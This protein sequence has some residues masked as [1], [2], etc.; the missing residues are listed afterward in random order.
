MSER[1]GDRVQELFDRAVALPPARRAAFLAATCADEPALHAEVASLLACDAEFTEGDGDAGVLKSPLVRAPEPANSRADE[2]PPAAW[3]PGPPVRIGRYRVLRRI[4]EGGMGAVYE[5]EQDSPHRLVA[6]KVIRPGLLSP[7][8]LKRF[9]QEVDVLGR[10]RHPGIAQIHE[11][12]MA[13]DG[14]PFFAMEL[15]RGLPLDEYADGQVLDLAARVGLVARVCDAVQHAHDRGVI[16]RDLKPANIL[17]EETGQPKVLDFGVARATGADLLTAAGLTRTGQLLGTPNYMS[18][19]QVTADPA[20]VDRRADV[21]ALGVILFELA[22]HRLPYRLED[23]PLAEAARLIMEHDPPRLGSLDPELGGDVETI[24]AKALEKDPA[25][26]YQSAATLAEDLR[27]WLAHKPILARPPSAL[28]HLGKFARRNKALVGGVAA[29]G[30]ALV[31]GLVGTIL[32]AVGEAKQRGL[33]EQNARAAIAEKREALFQAYRARLSAATAAISAHDVADAADQLEAA[34]E[35]LRDW[36]WRHLHSRLDDSSSVIP[37]PAGEHGFLLH[38]SDRLQV[39]KLTG[40]GL[41]LMNLEGGEDTTVPIDLTRVHAVDA[42]ATRRGLR[43]IAWINDAGFDLLDDTARVLCHVNVRKGHDRASGAVS[44]DG[45]RVACFSPDGAWWRLPVFDATSGK[46][47][48]ACFGHRLDG[49][50]VG[51]LAFSPD[52]TR[53]ASCGEDRVAQLWDPATG[54]LVATCRGHESM[55]VSAAFRPDGAR[56]LTTSTDGTVRQWDVAT[57]REVQPPYDRHYGVVT[58]AAYSPD[59]DWV[60]S[61]GA[62]RTVRVWRATGRQDLAVL[63]GHAARVSELAFAPGGRRLASLSRRSSLGDGTVRLWEVDPRAALPILRGHTSYV[64]PVAFSA[65]DRWIA[66]GGWDSAVR[67]WD[68]RTG[69]ACAV[70]ENSDVA[71]TLAFSPDGSRLVSARHD[72][73]QVW[74]VATG[75]RLKEIPVPAPNIL[76]LAFRPDG[77]TLAALDG[78]G[79]ATVLSVATGAAVAR[80]RMGSSHDTRALAYSPDGRWLAGAGADQKTVCVFDANT[81]EPSAQFAGHDDA[82]RTVTFAPD[83]RRLASCSSDRTVR[84]WQIDSGACQV[85]RGHTDEVFAVAFHPAGTRLASAGRDRAV[86]L[87]DL[88]RGEEVARLQGHTDYVWSLA[89]SPDGTTLASGSGDFTVRL[90]DTAPLKVR[91]QARREAEALRPEAERLVESLSRQK[92]DPAAVV[93][94]IRAD[95]VLSEPLRQAA[96]RAVLRR[97]TPAETA[98]GTPP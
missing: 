68:A 56:L 2:P 42:W 87:W 57:G 19:E 41:R 38:G 46:Q 93:D 74:E 6:L 72:R 50:D 96:L 45:T 78:S 82:I 28:Y 95:R 4:A 21:Y 86:W 71:K 24:V 77:A 34:P 63:H 35:D 85:L 70:L 9:A 89:F 16:H 80:L 5:A 76:A 84:V 44:W 33:A 91:Y 62:D 7:A 37:L 23:R 52:G 61:T 20:A 18:P 81:Y 36:E 73:L 43:I 58:S 14:Q 39:V 53:L 94:A 59:G 60:A 49:G 8:M 54:A 11:A 88:T 30:A 98:P 97:A 26:R 51:G 3:P 67:L 32:F 47:T 10:L 48:A 13:E 1:P 29:T 92:N 15:I 31:L 17:V 83:S 90:W 69:E 40:D 25:R 22:A 27:R 12:G 65:D 55:V 79:G 75:R 64:Y 66:S